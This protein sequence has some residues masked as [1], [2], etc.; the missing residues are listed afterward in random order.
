MPRA[1]A[2]NDCGRCDSNKTVAQATRRFMARI[3]WDAPLR[4]P[5][6]QPYYSVGSLR[7]TK[8]NPLCVFTSTVLCTSS[9]SKPITCSTDFVPLSPGTVK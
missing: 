6:V 5:V 4:R 8:L 7:K 9:S 2:Q 3:G 1:S